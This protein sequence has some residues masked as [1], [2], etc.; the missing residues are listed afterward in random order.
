MPSCNIWSTRAQ[1]NSMFFDSSEWFKSNVI[2]SERLHPG[3]T[4]IK[5]GIKTNCS[6]LAINLTFTLSFNVLLISKAAVN[7]A[8]LPLITSI[9][10]LDMFDNFS[11]DYDSETGRPSISPWPCLIP[12]KYSLREFSVLL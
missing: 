6:C 9:E 1:I 7:P 5:E 3:T 11:F 2:C 10:D 8:K 4:Q 12:K